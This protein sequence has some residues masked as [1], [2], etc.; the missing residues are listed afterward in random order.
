MLLQKM[1]A[2]QNLKEAEI[3][4]QDSLLLTKDLLRIAK[5]NIRVLFHEND[6]L[7][8]KIKTLR[9]VDTEPRRLIDWN[10]MEKGVN[11]ALQ[12]KYLKTL[13]FCIRDGPMI[14]EYSFSFSYSD[15][16]SQ[17]VT[18]NVNRNG[19][20]KHEGTPNQMST[21][22]CKMVPTLVQLLRTLDKTPDERTIVMKL[23]YYDDVM[24][25]DYEPPFFRSCTEEESNY[26]WTK[27]PMIMEV[28]IIYRKHLVLALTVKSLLDP[29][30][31]ENDDMQEH[32]KSTKP[33]CV[34]DNQPSDTDTDS[35][36]S[37]TQENQFIVEPVEKQADANNGEVDEDATQNPLENE[38]QLARVKNSRQ[39]DTLELTDILSYF[40][41]T[42]LVLSEDFMD[43]LEKEGVLSKTGEDTYIRNRDKAASLRIAGG[44]RIPKVQRQ[45]LKREVNVLGSSRDVDFSRP[46]PRKDRGRQ[47]VQCIYFN[48]GYCRYGNSCKFS[49]RI[50]GE[51]KTSSVATIMK[52][53]E[54]K[55]ILS[56]LPEKIKKDM[57]SVNISEKYAKTCL[58]EKRYGFIKETKRIGS[59]KVSDD[60][61]FIVIYWMTQ[62]VLEVFLLDEETRE[63]LKDASGYIRDQGT[64]DLCWTYV[65][66]D[67]V[68]ASRKLHGWD[69]KYTPLCT[70]YLCQNLDPEDYRGSLKR[71]DE[72]GGG[73][74]CYENDVESTL[75]YIQKFGIPEEE[76]G[77]EVFVCRDRRVL[78]KEDKL[79]KI[80]GIFKYP[81]LEEALVR[82]RTHPVGATLLG[83]DGWDGDQI[84]RGP[85]SKKAK[86]AGLHAVIMIDCLKI[87]GETVVVC[88]SSSGTDLGMEGYKGYI[89]VSV[90][91]ML[92]IA[93]KTETEENR[94]HRNCQVK[95]QHLL[96][97]FYSVDMDYKEPRFDKED[98]EQK[99]KN[100]KFKV[101]IE[102]YSQQVPPRIQGDH[103]RKQHQK[104]GKPQKR[105]NNLSLRGTKDSDSVVMDYVENVSGVKVFDPHHHHIDQ[106][107]IP[108]SLVE[109]VYDCWFESGSMPYAH[110]HYPFE[111]K[112]LIE[113]NFPGHFVAEG[114]DQ[115]RGWFY[116][117][118]VLSTALHRKSVVRNVI[119]NG[120]VLAEDGEK[121]SKKLQN[122]PPPLDLI[123]EYGADAL[124]LYL[125]NSLVVHAEPL[126]FKKGV[127]GVVKDVL[128]PFT[129]YNADGFL[130]Q[131]ARRLEIESCGP[132]VASDL[133]A[134]QSSNVLDQWIQS[135][136]QS[137][138]HFF[139][140]EMDGYRLYTV[141]PYLLKFLDKGG[142]KRANT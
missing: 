37:Q 95:P 81:T 124:W 22:A 62:G 77:K 99:R 20:K 106:M 112:E 28:G 56:E 93:G 49:H 47:N 35:E 121:I 11:D 1:V 128:L 76:E 25:P 97:D 12:R 53:P 102:R 120:L 54:R 5:L 42:S 23:L 127:L 109:D 24:P 90:Q 39:L 132:F 113:K 103:K 17:H 123:D 98:T 59:L 52:I 50:S 80:T 64:H 134:L 84:Y 66:S 91:V 55:R 43:Q 72:D 19:N 31:D 18:M 51:E 110:I 30:E 141:V 2:V 15:S 111:N 33:D 83:F 116:T 34:H 58:G 105:H 38:Q 100:E 67:M 68:S 79:H 82:L 122:Y 131:N 115:T 7:D 137:L 87:H 61:K 29:S 139:R 89:V 41:D 138:V 65:S 119:C 125:I 16:G 6:A 46:R 104:H 57:E 26:V 75:A 114:L 130:V 60:K 14:E 27:D 10:W 107:T 94:G 108:S 136:T 21:S 71:C 78:C 74:R 88:K 32:G 126:R 40:Q 92:M 129:W 101:K 63:R 36:I 96:Y 117:L 86:L 69:L 8:M 133:E 85:C 48:S 118:M 9:Q 70:R 73:H 142:L 135:A 44:P 45:Y 13:V 4:E 140:Q 3:T